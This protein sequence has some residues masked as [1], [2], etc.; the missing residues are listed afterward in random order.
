MDTQALL[1]I[2]AVFTGVAAIALLIQAG[3]LF[4]IYKSSRA[5]QEKVERLTPKI[6]SLVDSS[7]AAVDESK[8]RIIEIS[9]KTSEILDSARRQMTRVEALLEDAATRAEVQLDRAELVLDDAMSRAQQTVATVQSGILKPL[10]EINGVALGVR[11]ALQY[12]LRGGRPSPDRA[13]ADEE[14]FI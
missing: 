2:M 14:M 11:A 6:E 3:F 5:M 4:G 9:T 10:R 7:K 13:T 12:F 8:T 1:I